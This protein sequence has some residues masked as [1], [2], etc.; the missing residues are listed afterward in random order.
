VEIL[1]ELAALPIFRNS[2][3]DWSIAVGL[4]IG[5]FFALLTARRFMRRYYQRL[6]QTPETELLELP[7]QVLSRTGLPFFLVLSLFAGLGTLPTSELTGRVLRSAV[8]IAL[9][10][11]VGVWASA[12][13][14]ALLDRRR[15][16]IVETDRATAGSLGILGFIA[17]AVIWTVVVLLI[18][19]NVGVDVTALVA[20]LGIGGVAVALALQNILGDLFASLSITFDKPFVVGD[21]LIVEDCLGSVEYIGLK[22]TRLRSLSGEQIIMSNADLLGSRVRNSKHRPICW[23]AFPR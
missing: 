2:I 22:S 11:Q 5:L 14:L 18:L 4:A 7:L 12:A 9:F 10:W 17:R 13:A 23:N 8:T 1:N 19:E 3:L 16:R 20:G 6:A 21:F 15:R